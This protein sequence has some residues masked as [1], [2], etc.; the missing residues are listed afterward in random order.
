V[1]VVE[2]EILERVTR[3]AD[4]IMARRR[5]RPIPDL[6]DLPGLDRSLVTV[7][8]PGTVNLAAAPREVLVALPGIS[9]ESA[10]RL[11][12]RR[13][14][15]RPIA[16]LDELAGLLSPSARGLL[17]A[18]YSDLARLATFAAPQLKV[19]AEGDVE[20]EA[21]RATIEVMVVPL[22]ERLA[23]IRRRMW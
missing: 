3:N 19:T 2:R 9:P 14:A 17:L 4:A 8:G 13:T 7:D 16:S 23:V 11:L 18:S 1:N 15:G 20:G 10:E 22:P 21:P 5:L 12:A 6:D